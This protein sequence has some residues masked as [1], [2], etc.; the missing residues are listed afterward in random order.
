MVLREIKEYLFV[1]DF[2]GSYEQSPRFMEAYGDPLESENATGSCES[3]LREDLA[4]AMLEI[5][6]A[7]HRAPGKYD[8][9]T[10]GIGNL[11]ISITVNECRSTLLVLC[12]YSFFFFFPKRVKSIHSRTTER[13]SYTC[14]IRSSREDFYLHYY[15]LVC[16]YFIF[17]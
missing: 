10:N 13:R 5:S 12:C 9:A 4:E 14:V 2:V 8:E 7:S 17:C 3:Q 6:I 15:Y 16:L 11:T 1:F